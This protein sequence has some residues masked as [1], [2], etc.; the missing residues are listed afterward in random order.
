MAMTM[1]ALVVVT[2]AAT[3]VVVDADG[4]GFGECALTIPNTMVFAS[5]AECQAAVDHYAD[6]VDVPYDAHDFV[7]CII[8]E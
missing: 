3:S 2:C 7:F 4:L 8:G 1:F 6:E 5:Q